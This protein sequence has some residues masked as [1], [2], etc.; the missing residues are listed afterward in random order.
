MGALRL[1][2]AI[3]GLTAAV[4]GCSEP[5]GPDPSDGNDDGADDGSTGNGQPQNQGDGFVSGSRLRARFIGGADG[6]KQFLGFHDD[7]RDEDCSFSTASDGK[8]RCVPPSS[9]AS[10]FVDA[11]CNQPVVLVTVGCDPPKY[12]NVV[13]GGDVGDCGGGEPSRMRLFTMGARVAS[14]AQSA[15]TNAFGTCE[16]TTLPPNDLYALD[17][18]I[19]ASSFVEGNVTVE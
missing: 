16:Q 6:S 15:Y 18:E 10:L 13:E 1:G 14:A 17:E 5:I 2:W 12:G 4:M 19:P 3:V 9:G 8:L 11:Q 7:E